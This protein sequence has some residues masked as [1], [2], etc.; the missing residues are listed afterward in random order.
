MELTRRRL[1]AATALLAAGADSAR[2]QRFPGRPVTLWIPWPAGGA[3]DLTLRL[4]AEATGRHLGQKVLTDNRAGAGGTLVMPVL[5][6]AAPDGYTVAQMPQ[7]V[8]RAPWTQHVAWDPIRDT[9]PILQI[10]G[11]TFGLVVPEASPWRSLDDVFGWARQHPGRLTIATNGVGTTPHVVLDQLFAERGLSYV[12]VPYKG[13]SEQM[14]AVSTGQVMAGVNSNGFAPF[15][16]GG[17]LRLLV[18]F[19]AQ[20]TKRWPQVPTLKE[21]G[22]GIVANSPYGLAGPAGMAPEVVRVLHDAFRAAM[23]EPVHVAELAKYDQE[24]AYLGPEDY[25][26]AMRAAYEAERKA[27]E[28]LGLTKKG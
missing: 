6:Q 12:H 7:P 2:A 24:L 11:V 22:H 9:T 27:V 28:R 15:V 1:L 16:D 25:G 13:T 19:G 17:Q 8:F 20:R 26:R 5:Q 4:L 10:S 3:T 18:T 21:L 14:V 23:Q